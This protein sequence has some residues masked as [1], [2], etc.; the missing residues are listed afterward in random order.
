MD[1]VAF[2]AYIINL[3]DFN[4]VSFMSYTYNIGMGPAPMMAPISP[5]PWQPASVRAPQP[6]SL[7]AYI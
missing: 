6:H 1:L 4:L 2:F 5:A 3:S 7:T